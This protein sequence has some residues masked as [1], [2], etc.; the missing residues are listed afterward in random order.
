[1]SR[2]EVPAASLALV[3]LKCGIER[4]ADDHSMTPSVS[5]ASPTTVR[6]LA[7]GCDP[8]RRPNGGHGARP[9]LAFSIG[10]DK[11]LEN[12]PGELEEVV[13]SEEAISSNGFLEKE[14]EREP[15]RQKRSAEV[16]SS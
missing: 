2:S 1:M 7:G 13:E 11:A 5:R 12:D 8:F 6:P 16:H 3:Q 4:S 14:I 9:L 10:S 15:S